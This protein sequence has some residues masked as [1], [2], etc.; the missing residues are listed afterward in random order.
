MQPL[1]CLTGTYSDTE[2][3]VAC[4]VCPSGYSCLNVSDAP[5]ECHMGEYSIVG[6]VACKVL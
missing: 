5:K 6:D 2:G 4:D 3:A 1:P